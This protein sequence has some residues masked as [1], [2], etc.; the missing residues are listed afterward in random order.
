MKT[1]LKRYYNEG[2]IGWALLWLLG[3]P[4]PVLLIFYLLGG[5]H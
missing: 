5:R 4:L 1:N 3:V 2:K